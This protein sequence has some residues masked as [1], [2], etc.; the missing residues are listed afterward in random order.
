MM[1]TRTDSENQYQSKDIFLDQYTTTPYVF[2]KI[3]CYIKLKGHTPSPQHAVF[4]PNGHPPTPSSNKIQPRHVLQSN[5]WRNVHMRILSNHRN[6]RRTCN[7]KTFQDVVRKLN[8]SIRLN[9]LSNVNCVS[10]SFQVLIQHKNIIFELFLK[11]LSTDSNSFDMVPEILIAEFFN[12]SR[13][14]SVVICV[15]KVMQ[16][17]LIF[18]S[19]QKEKFSPQVPVSSSYFGG[20]S[21]KN[22]MEREK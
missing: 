7:N 8:D 13:T 10:K 19:I 1:H 20:E 14:E 4:L 21:S 5:K 12:Y 18:V 15:L 6:S 2:L 11:L 9:H 16:D 17:V 3:A 22:C